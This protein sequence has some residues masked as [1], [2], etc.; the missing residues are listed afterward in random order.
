LAEKKQATQTESP[1]IKDIA[2]F[3]G[4]FEGEGN[5]LVPTAKNRSERC[6]VTQKD[7]WPLEK[8][9]RQFGGQIVEHRQ[10][11]YPDEVYHKWQCFGP[12]ARGVLMTIYPF[13]SPRRQEKARMVLAGRKDYIIGPHIVPPKNIISGRFE[14]L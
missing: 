2:W 12:R 5:M 7:R 10:T 8:I 1:T 3:A 9:Q 6:D 14:R 11:R 13:L 4:F